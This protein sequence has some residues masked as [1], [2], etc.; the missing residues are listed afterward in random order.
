MENPQGPYY[1]SPTR[2]PTSGEAKTA[3]I[4]SYITIVGW[5]IS[6]FAL[7]KD[8]KTDFS[9][10]HIRQTLLL[11]LAGLGWYIASMIIGFII[12]FFFVLS[13]LVNLG[14]LIIWIIGLIGA[15]AGEKKPMPFIGEPA[16]RIFSSI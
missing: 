13:M 8:S 2:T 11:W 7:Y 15:I 1:G 3:A 4:V 10:F 12:P 14:F 5:L 6:Y 9:A 16:Q